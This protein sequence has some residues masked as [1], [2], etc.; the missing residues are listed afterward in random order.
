MKDK[1]L[2][3]LNLSVFLMMI[4]VG[5]IVTLL[6]QKIVELDGNGKHV[7]Y[8]ASM[9]AIAYIVLQVPIGT[10]ADRFGFKFFLILGYLLCFLTGLCFYFS[11]SSTMLFFSRLFQGAGEAPIW[12]LAPALLSVK[13]PLMK[14]KV[15]GTYNAVIHIGLT[16]GPILAVFLVKVWQP[17]DIFLLYAFACLLSAVLIYL[18]IEN[19]NYEDKLTSS[20]TFSRILSL[21]KNSKAFITL[22]GITLYGTGY[23]IFLTTIPAY[24]LQEKGFSSIYIGVFF[25]LFYVATSISQIITGQLSDKFGPSRFMILGLLIASSGLCITPIL[26]LFG[27]LVMLT[28]SSLG[29]GV[30]YL[31]SMIFLN[32]TVD[33]PFKGTISGAYYL[34]WGIGMFFGPPALSMVSQGASFKLAFILYSSILFV[35]AMGMLFVMCQNKKDMESF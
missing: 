35:I 4:G 20:F 30:F 14:G 1:T 6:P 10:M 32:E 34:F 25:S 24:L 23:G 2:L 13:Y 33:E 3:G 12:A 28:I 7:G 27:I 18:F 9:F 5:M 11:T 17:N 31:A 22:L 26:D 21:S 29:L 19:V 15:M 16:L 8:L